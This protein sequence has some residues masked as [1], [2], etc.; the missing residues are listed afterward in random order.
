MRCHVEARPSLIS[1]STLGLP[2]DRTVQVDPTVS[3]K[4]LHAGLKLQRAFAA[5]CSLQ[6]VAFAQDPFFYPSSPITEASIS[7]LFDSVI[8]LHLST[9]SRPLSA[10]GSAPY[11]EASRDAA[12][13]NISLVFALAKRAQ[14]DVDFH[15]DY[16]LDPLTE[17]LVWDVLRLA[18][19][20]VNQWDVRGRLRRITLGHC[21]KLSLFNDAELDRLVHELEGFDGQVHFVALPPSDMFMQ[22][23]GTPYAARSRA[24]F[25]ALELVKRGISCSIGL[26]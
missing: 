18:K 12:L 8:D 20:A 19:V 3:L 6:L 25:P 21:T 22:G 9:S 14:V 2:A 5:S 17:P 16:D 13:R 23:R 1:S 26:K 24:T 7:A 4:C 10:I 11:V 15:L